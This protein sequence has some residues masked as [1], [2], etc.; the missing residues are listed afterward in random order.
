MKDMEIRLDYGGSGEIPFF[1]TGNIGRVNGHTFDREFQKLIDDD[2]M[3]K[4]VELD[5]EASCIFIYCMNEEALRWVV[6]RV[7]AIEE[8]YERPKFEDIVKAML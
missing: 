6:S 8:A 4:S 5:S 7:E 2:G 3:G 1:V